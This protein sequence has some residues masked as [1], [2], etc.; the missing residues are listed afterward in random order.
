M[1]K[2]IAVILIIVVTVSVVSVSCKH[3]ID[4]PPAQEA[5]DKQAPEVCFE[6]DVLPLFQSYCGKSGCHNTASHKGDYKLNS[7]ANI[8]LKGVVP[9][10]APVS[11]LYSVLLETG[12]SK[13]P[14]AGNPD[15]TVD[16]KTLIR[17]WINQGAKNTVNCAPLCDTLK[18]KYVADI[19]PIMDKYCT[20][21]HG[22]TNVQGSIKFDTY[23]LLKDQVDNNPDAFWGSIIHDPSY[24]AMPK[25]AAQLK[26]CEIKKI[27]KW[28]AA[29]ALNN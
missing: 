15:L 14:Q 23:P 24:A 7:Y 8:V 27:E 20:G 25:Y 5:L 12:S 26:A 11:R 19:K 9:G 2:A 21:C 6:N 28:I 22:G 17:Q 29:G 3:S 4:Y 1:K 13:M 18:Y 10:N 16:Q